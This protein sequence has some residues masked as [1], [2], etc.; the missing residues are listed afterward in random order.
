[1]D[2]YFNN[3]NLNLANARVT[4]ESDLTPI[5]FAK[6]V[7]ADQLLINLYVADGAGGFVDLS[8]YPT[9]RVGIGGIDLAPTAGT[10]EFDE[11]GT[12]SVAYN[13]SAAAMQSAMDEVSGE[14]TSVLKHGANAWVVKFSA[15]GAQTLP[16]TDVSTLTPDCVASVARLVTG[17]GTTKEEWLIRIFQAPYAYNETWSAISNGK[18]GSLNIGTENLMTALGDDK[19]VSA[20]FEVELTDTDGN[21]STIAQVP[22]VVTEQV[23]GTGVAGSSDFNAFLTYTYESIICVCSDETSA[24]T[25]GNDK[26]TF[27]VPYAMTLTEVRASVGTAPTGQE[28][29][30]DVNESGSSVLSTLITIAAGEETSTTAPTPPVISDSALADD[31]EITID[32]DQVGS[33][34]EGAGL[35]V[36]LNGYRTT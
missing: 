4:S 14:T 29:I 9:I 15:V 7:S 12:A 21:V 24:L 31:A 17:D 5:D 33:G 26:L 35:K 27:R 16:T 28:I 18:S 34:T 8:T 36:Y 25:T 20:Y 22:V 1:M 3:A 6:F 2:V 19:A 13:A 10:I 23:L 30:V 11:T 32:L